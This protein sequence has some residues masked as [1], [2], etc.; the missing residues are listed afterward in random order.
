[1]KPPFKKETPVKPPL[2][3]L[4]KARIRRIKLQYLLNISFF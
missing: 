4:E 2:T 3:P 1:M